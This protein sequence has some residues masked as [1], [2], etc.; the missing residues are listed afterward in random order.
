MK[1]MF[2]AAFA[3]LLSVSL[4]SSCGGEKPAVT[5]TDSASAVPSTTLPAPETTVPGTDPVTT[6]PET[7]PPATEA[8]DTPYDWAAPVPES[9]AKGLSYFDD[10]VFLGD[11]RIGGFFMSAGVLNAEYIYAQGFQVNQFATAANVV[12]GNGQAMTAKE[13]LEALNGKF[14]KVYI[15][16]GLNELGW[17]SYNF[18][19]TKVCEI[20]DAV[21]EQQ[22]DALIYILSVT[23]V[24]R[25]NAAGIAWHSLEK[26][27]IFN[28]K[29]K[30]AAED[31]KVFYV[32]WD[33]ALRDSSRYLK[34]E[35]AAVDGAHFTREGYGILRDYLL[36]HTADSYKE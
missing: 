4:L 23:P 36:S 14:G 16:V 1:K 13:A 28:G 8:P 10:A 19:Y 25:N 32:D 7:T 34:E 22:P 20:V 17:E 30:Q 26:I 15:A 18:F 29:L 35:L 2:S 3:A 11:S 5:T 21:R 33:A 24:T 12:G 31:E 27:D 6:P 9:E